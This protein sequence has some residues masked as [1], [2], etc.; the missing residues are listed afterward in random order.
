MNFYRSILTPKDGI[1]GVRIHDVSLIEEKNTIYFE[2]I[3]IQSI[4]HE[5]EVD[6]KVFVEL[7]ET[8]EDRKPIVAWK[9]I[10]HDYKFKFSETVRG[11]LVSEKELNGKFLKI[12]VLPN[13][14]SSKQLVEW[15]KV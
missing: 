3:L 15:H 6:A 11:S 9:A 5:R 7:F 4:N 8:K 14:D 1:S 10:T 12:I 2:I 13:G